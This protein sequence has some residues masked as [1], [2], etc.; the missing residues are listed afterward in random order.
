MTRN[1]R[2]ALVALLFASVAAI[3]AL[4]A[5]TAGAQG[6]SINAGPQAGTVWERGSTN[7]ASHAAH[8]SSPNLIYHGGDVVTAGTTVQPI[9]WGTSWPS[10]SGDE[11]SGIDSFY[12]GVGGS[13]YLGTNGEYTDSKG[14]VSTSVTNATH[15]VDAS[16]APSHA[17]QTSDILAEVAK[18]YPNPSPNTYFPVYIDQPRGH[19]GYCA[20]HSSGTING[21]HVTFGFFFKLDGDPGC[22]PQSSG[23][24]SQGLKASVNVSGHELS[25]MLTDEDGNAWYDSKGAENADKCA[26]TFGSRLLP[27]GGGTYKIQGNWSNNAYNANRGYTDSSKGY[28]RGCIDGT[29][30]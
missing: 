3:A 22:D 10:Y 16:A 13:S 18:L 1:H 5:A 30:A 4:A 17:P 27:I 11:M 2:R 28:Q 26:W 20:W 7:A 21:V 24:G 14:S 9:F 8:T 6:P 12:H 29:N 19:T 25:E 23:D 15:V